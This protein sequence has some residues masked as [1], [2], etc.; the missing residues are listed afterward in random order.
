MS[1]NFM[2]QYRQTLQ[3]GLI[4]VA[5]ELFPEE[6][7]K[8]PYSILDGVYC[9]F[10]QSLV[11]PREV[12][13]IESELKKWVRQGT[14][15]KLAGREG[16]RYKYV[17]G[18]TVIYTIYQALNDTSPIKDFSIIHFPPGFILHFA[19][20]ADGTNQ[21]VL[22]EKLSATYTE[23]QRWLENLNLDKVKD[24]NSYIQNGHFLELISIAEALQEKKIADI[25][26]R[27][28][29]EKKTIKMI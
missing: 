26:D 19:D 25:A 13:L 1:E 10:S 11:S 3:L 17:L 29:R 6:K 7:L 4:K 9:E 23:T 24:V 5:K 27:I 16:N 12:K 14:E 21:F 28:L 8:I 2:R 15:I 20:E 22:P 18:D